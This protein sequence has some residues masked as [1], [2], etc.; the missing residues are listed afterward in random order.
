MSPPTTKHSTTHDPA[1][2]CRFD[3]RFMTVH[4]A[5]GREGGDNQHSVLSWLI[6]LDS[7]L[8]A[9]AE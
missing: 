9:G 8:A 5:Q 4:T 7:L 1:I 6:V 2:V 3:L